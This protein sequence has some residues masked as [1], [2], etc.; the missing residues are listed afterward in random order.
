MTRLAITG[1]T[2]FVGGAV[3]DRLSNIEGLTVRALARRPQPA[4]PGVQWVPGA[5]DDDAALDMLV[6][7]AD[8]VIHI[9]G[10]VNARDRAGFAAGN[11]QGTVALVAAMTRKSVHRL[12]HV[13][14]L[15]AREPQ[16]SDY[17]WSKAEAERIVMSSPHDWT[18]VRPPAIYGPGDAEMLELFQM[19][20]RGTVLLPPG[21]QTSIIHV[22][23]L[24]RLLIELATVSG[25]PHR[26]VTY[27]VGDGRA[28]GWAQDELARAIGLAVGRPRVRIIALPAPLLKLG[29]RL[30][31]LLR[32]SKARLTP[33]RAAYFCHPDW[34]ARPELAPPASLWVPQIATA[35]GLASTANAYRAKGHLKQR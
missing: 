13:S 8:A 23:D 10:V 33:D 15:A 32:G 7:G 3:L 20:A 25:P 5:L 19:A 22:D 26:A 21:G 2:G 11:A 35:E 31:R 12:V 14:S 18:M 27:E 4:R 6:D 28:K 17:G 30:D 16:L 29:A 9:A 24:A 1:G 34:V